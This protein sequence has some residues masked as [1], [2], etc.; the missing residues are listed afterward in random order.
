MKTALT[1]ITVIILCG[2]QTFYSSVVT[3]TEIRKS[4][5]N[6]LGVMYRAGRI[7]EETD[8]R[9]TQL[10]TDFKTTAKSLELALLAYKAGTTTNEPTAKLIEVKAVVSQLIDVLVPLAGSLVTDKHKSNLERATKL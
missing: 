7:S 8:H 10:D 2:C 9:I 3:V 5:L 4:V 6:E 1:L